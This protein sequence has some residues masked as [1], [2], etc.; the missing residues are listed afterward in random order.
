[1]RKEFPKYDIEF[2]KQFNGE[3]EEE[4][5]EWYYIS[6]MQIAGREHTMLRDNRFGIQCETYKKSRS[7][8]IDDVPNEFSTIQELLYALNMK[9][10]AI[11]EGLTVKFYGALINDKSEYE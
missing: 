4:D 7:F 10:K 8:F 9:I 5:L 2:I 1:M 6:S 11:K 3:V